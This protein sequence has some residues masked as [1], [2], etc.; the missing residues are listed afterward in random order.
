MHDCINCGALFSGREVALT[1]EVERL[2]GALEEAQA[3]V[4]N[5]CASIGST[6][7]GEYMEGKRVKA[8]IDAALAPPSR[9]GD[10]CEHGCQKCVGA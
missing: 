3:F 1:A 4:G 5:W 2:R 8:L 7:W 6:E 9:A 10:D